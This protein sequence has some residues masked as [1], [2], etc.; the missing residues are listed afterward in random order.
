V[1]QKKAWKMWESIFLSFGSFG[2]RELL[3]SDYVKVKKK[4]KNNTLWYLKE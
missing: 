3:C 2:Y 4:E 1:I